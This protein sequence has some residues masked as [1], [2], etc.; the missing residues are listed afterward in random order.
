MPR[1]KILSLLALLF[2][3]LVPREQAVAQS[4]YLGP[5]TD[6]KQLQATTAQNRQRIK[7][8][9]IQIIARNVFLTEAEAPRF[10]ALYDEY[11]VA[12]DHVL[13]E[14]VA[15]L[16]TY[17]ETY[18]RMDDKQAAAMLERAFELENKRTQ[19]KRTWYKKFS[20]VVSPKK[21]AQFFQVENQINAALDLQLASS[22]P[23]IQ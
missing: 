9:K 20:K 17:A 18:H 6:P 16:Q 10:W 3:G 14:R 23:L 21:A 8:E 1:H 11:C 5:G 15:M 7:A 19:L 22:L 13:D 2:A 12:L 4:I